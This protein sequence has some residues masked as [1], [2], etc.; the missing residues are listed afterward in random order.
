MLPLWKE[1]SDKPRQHVKKQRRHF[2]H[3]GLHSQSYGFSSS[4]VWMWE[5]D[6]KEGWAPKNWRFQIV[7]MEKTLESP[8][9]CKEIKLVNPKGNKLWIFSGRMILKLELQY[10]G[11]KS[12]LIGK[13]P[14]AGKDWGQEEEGATR[15]KMVREHHGPNGYE[16][17]QTLGDSEGQG[18]LVHCSPWGHK[19][20]DTTEWLNNNTALG[21]F[22]LFYLSCYF[23]LC[24]SIVIIPLNNLQVH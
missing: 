9:D 18:S 4:H 1:S 23:S 10:I 19:E 12:W 24:A 2:A 17:E 16:F 14:D 15:S 22:A 21:C 11:H 13:D 5:L 8:L 7:V 6:H 20:S 3:K